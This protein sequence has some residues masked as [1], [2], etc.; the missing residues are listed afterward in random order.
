MFFCFDILNRKTVAL[1]CPKKG[2]KN[3][4]KKCESDDG[5]KEFPINGHLFNE[6]SLKDKIQEITDKEKVHTI[7]PCT[8]MIRVFH[9]LYFFSGLQK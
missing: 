2:L 3:P 9:K 7:P 4:I 1:T 6:A 8:C 5:F